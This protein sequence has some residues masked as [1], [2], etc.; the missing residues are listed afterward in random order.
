MPQF[1]DDPNIIPMLTEE[2]FGGYYR[3]DEDLENND[4][5]VNG[6][7][8]DQNSHTLFTPEPN[9]MSEVYQP[10]YYFKLYVLNDIKPDENHQVVIAETGNTALNIVDVKIDGIVGPN[11]RTRNSMATNITIK[12]TEPY[13]LNLP[14]RLVAAARQLQ[15]RNYLKASFMLRLKLQGYNSAGVK[16]EIGDGWCWRIMI[17][18]VKTVVTNQGAE[19]T[20]S[21][22]PYPEVALQ[23][24]NAILPTN[25]TVE[26]ST[27]G[28]I[29]KGVADKLNAH[30]QEVHGFPF[31]TYE[32]VDVPYPEGVSDVARPFDHSVES[33]I[34]I[35]EN[36]RAHSDGSII[37]GQFSQGTDIPS[38]VD[39][40][41]SASLTAVSLGTVERSL[42]ASVQD[43]GSPVKPTSVMHRIETITT[44]LKFDPIYGDYQKHIK[45]V[46]H[47]YETMRIQSGLTSANTDLRTG[48]RE[49]IQHA[50]KRAFLCKQYDYIFTGLNTEVEKFDIEINFRWAVSAP[51]LYQNGPDGNNAT[52]Y[53]GATV[54]RHLRMNENPQSPQERRQAI[55]ELSQTRISLLGEIRGGS[56]SG[57]DLNQRQAEYDRLTTQQGQLMY[58]SRREGELRAR[59]LLDGP[60][61]EEYDFEGTVLAEDLDLEAS[62]VHPLT[63]SQ[64]AENPGIQSGLGMPNYRS[65]AK[66]VYGT[67]LN[68]LYGSFDGNLQTITLDIKG[69][70]YWLGPNSTP[71]ANFDITRPVEASTSTSDAPSLMNGEH[72]FAFNFGLP[73][74]YSGETGSVSL[75][76]DESYSGFYAVSKIEHMFVEGRFT[77]RLEA[78]RIPGI[79]FADLNQ[80]TVEDNTTDRGDAQ[81]NPPR[82]EPP[83]S[84]PAPEASTRFNYTPIDSSLEGLDEDDL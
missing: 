7:D 24:R 84:L 52:G 28:E 77:Q 27:V 34:L 13:G 79:T 74:G 26:G 80:G 11:M 48:A 61:A 65:G 73:Q 68:Q 58:E 49:K 12:L 39:N 15:V 9:R 50:I 53:D 42:T 20:I 29:L 31:I 25:V 62:L 35:E 14:D 43:E 59:N 17:T 6:S 44:P 83:V 23:D 72:M 57:D 82:S 38:L 45:F 30:I 63:I 36:E 70:P 5:P 46:I 21:A 18:D 1:P 8:P 67:L 51:L 16:V 54:P 55:E 60:D 19:H 66:S 37:R 22:I 64:T 2:D 69:D 78:Y 47:P 33:D 3:E 40:V 76:K 10:T 56:L 41:F 4:T 75:G 81:L 32:F 71:D